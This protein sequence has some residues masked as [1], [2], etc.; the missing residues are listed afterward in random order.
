MAALLSVLSLKR[1]HRKKHFS[2]SFR[3]TW[4]RHGQLVHGSDGGLAKSDGVHVDVDEVQ[5]LVKA[6]GEVVQQLAGVDRPVQA[7]SFFF[8]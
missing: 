2:N 5:H 4:R 1:H 8:T 7:L 3:P 6:E